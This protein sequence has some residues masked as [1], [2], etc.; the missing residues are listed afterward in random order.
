[1]HGGGFSMMSA[2]TPTTT[3]TPAA[4]PPNPPPLSFR[5]STVSLRNTQYRLAPVGRR[6][7]YQNGAEPWLNDHADFS[8]IFV[9]GDSAGG[10]MA[11]TLAY[12]VGTIGLPGM[13]LVGAFLTHPYFGGVEAD[14]KMWMYMCPTNSGFDDPRMKPPVEDLAVIG[15]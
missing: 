5:S 9:G 11:H 6:P 10:N 1:M 12:R 2:F 3:A 7:Q 15:G 8:R 14:D 13:K 4:S